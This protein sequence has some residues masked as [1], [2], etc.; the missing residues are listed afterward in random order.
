MR[1][2][3]LVAVVQAHE[4][5]R[6]DD[7]R[8]D[9]EADRL[10][11]VVDAEHADRQ[12]HAERGGPGVGVGEA[13]T[14]DAV[15]PEDDRACGRLDERAVRLRS[16]TATAAAA[17]HVDAPASLLALLLGIRGH[18]PDSPSSVPVCGEPEA[19]PSGPGSRCELLCGG[20]ELRR[21]VA[22]AGCDAARC[23]AGAGDDPGDED[24]ED[25]APVVGR[26]D[27]DLSLATAD[28]HLF[29][30]EVGHGTWRP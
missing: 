24:E 26:R 27:A 13:A 14:E 7:E 9:D 19:D 4:L 12:Q 22:A 15:A 25:H 10:Q 3:Q 16:V 23:D 2:T 5:A 17:G 6:D 8:Q 30:G 29:G 1:T 21:R 18:R 20:A 11:P 28:A